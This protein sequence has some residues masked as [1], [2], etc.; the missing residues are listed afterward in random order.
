MSEKEIEVTKCVTLRQ[1]DWSF[2]CI[3]EKTNK[4]KLGHKW[5]VSFLPAEGLF[6]GELPLAEETSHLDIIN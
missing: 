3:N 1:H 2:T 6:I 5:N 4:N